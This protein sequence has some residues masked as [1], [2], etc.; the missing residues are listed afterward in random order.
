MADEERRRDQELE[1]E[2]SKRT[3]E[4]ELECMTKTRQ[5]IDSQTQLVQAEKMA[6]LGNL[7]AGL[8]H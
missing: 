5:L 1:A 6:A 7:A 8:A 2:I 3:R 4:L